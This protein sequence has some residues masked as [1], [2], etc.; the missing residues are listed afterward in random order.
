MKKVKITLNEVVKKDLKIFS[1]L[2]INGGVTVLAQRYLQ[3]GELSIVFGMAVNYILYRIQK[4]LDN[5]GY[6]QALKK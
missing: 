4:E 6:K 2:I 5:S 3:T 1:Y